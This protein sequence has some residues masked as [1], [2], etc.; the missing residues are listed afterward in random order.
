M[1]MHEYSAHNRSGTPAK[2]QSATIAY[3][4]RDS[5]YLNITNRCSNR[6][7]F[8]PKFENLTL[9]GHNLGLAGEPT[10]EEV[11]TAVGETKGGDEVVFCGFGESLIRLDLVVPVARELKRRGY[12]IRINTDGQANLVHGRNILPELSGLADT[13]SVSLNAPDAATYVKLCNTPFGEAGF[14]GVCDFIRG[15][16]GCVPLVVA[17]AV[18]VPGVDVDACRALAASL[19]AEF[20]VREYLEAG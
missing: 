13:I 6:C 14:S 19:G 2:E 17:S 9:K 3:R 7:T 18:T 11:M 10:F 4:I 5:L 8:C 15:A 12:R 20:R 16:A 1:V